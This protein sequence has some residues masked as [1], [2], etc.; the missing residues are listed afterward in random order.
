MTSLS[1]TRRARVQR[2]DSATIKRW[3]SVD[4]RYIVAEVRS[5]VGHYFLAGRRLAAGEYPISFHRTRRAA[6]LACDNHRK[7]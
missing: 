7:G 5:T 2:T 1:F 3:Q 6:E 4:G